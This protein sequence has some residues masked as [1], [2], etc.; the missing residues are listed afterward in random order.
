V[1][2]QV[3]RTDTSTTNCGAGLELELTAKTYDNTNR[4]GGRLGYQSVG[5][6]GQSNISL[7]YERSF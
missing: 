7:F 6:A 5:G 1:L 3:V 4:V 2:C